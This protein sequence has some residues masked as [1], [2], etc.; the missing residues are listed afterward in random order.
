MHSPQPNQPRAV[1]V[2]DRRYRTKRW[3]RIRLRVL[4]RDGWACRVVQGCPKP[5]T[6]ADHVIPVYDG[7]PDSLFFDPANLRAACRNHNLARGLTEDLVPVS[8]AVVTKDY[9]A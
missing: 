1:R 2:T 8:T 6:V 3:E 4:N 7:M 9:S 5:A